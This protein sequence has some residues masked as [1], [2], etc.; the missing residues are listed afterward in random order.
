MDSGNTTCPQCE[1]EIDDSLSWCPYC[2][3]EQRPGADSPTPSAEMAAE[4]D[5]MP[6][7]APEDPFAPIRRGAPSQE[8]LEATGS[9]NPTSGSP[10]VVI[11]ALA[12]LLLI[13]AA[14]AWFFLMR[15]DNRGDLSVMS[16]GPGDCWNDPETLLSDSEITDV[17]QVPCEEPHDNEV[18]SVIEVPGGRDAAFPGEFELELVSFEGCMRDFESYFGVPY[19]ESPLEIYTLFP[20]QLS[21]TDGDRGVVCSAYPLDGMAMTGSH[22]DS[23]E[24]LVSPAIDMSGVGD[25]PALADSAITVTQQSIDYFDG[26]TDEELNTTYETIPP[27][28]MPLYKSESMVNVRA[29]TLGCDFEELNILVMNRSGTLTYVTEI[30]GLIAEDVI[31]TG[32]FVTG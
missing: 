29:V 21:W 1:R 16:I 32:F 7:V 20:T 31:S 2:G 18:F 10:R 6:D 22:R 23:G 17:P 27:D 12:V 30:G 26:L 13:G 4:L 8:Y 5:G 28:L 9:S 11:L 14:A 25:C 24:R 3:A 19:E 15:D